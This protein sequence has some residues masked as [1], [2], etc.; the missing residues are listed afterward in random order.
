MTS[1]LPPWPPVVPPE[2]PGRGEFEMLKQLVADTRARLNSIDDTG[3]KGVAVVQSQL[4]EVVKDL[5]ELKGDV[6]TKF[7]AHEIVHEKDQQERR[8]GRR[9]LI[10][11]S[12]TMITTMVAVIGL[13]IG[14]LTNLR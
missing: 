10:G 12:L 5:T 13:L 3:T 14:V 1:P 2:S 11:I 4:T 7:T 8:D 9:W 6:A